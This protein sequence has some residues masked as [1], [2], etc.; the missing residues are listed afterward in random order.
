[1]LK[2]LTQL[3]FL[4]KMVEVEA[5]LAKKSPKIIL[6]HGA[7]ASPMSFNYIKA[8]LPT[9]EY[10]V[11]D[12]STVDGFYPN[13]EKMVD[14]LKGDNK[15]YVLSHSMGGIYAM[16]LTQY[17]NI[18]RSISVSTP[19]EGLGIA[20]WAKYMMPNYQ[21]FKDVSLRAMPI[22]QLKDIKIKMP[23]TQVV[24]TRGS[25]PWVKDPNDGVVTIASMSTRKDI[26]YVY[27]KES[28][29]EIMMSDELV[30]IVKKQ[31]FG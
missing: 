22:T 4:R 25:V 31:F 27:I 5:A 3:F 21:L 23:W 11:V 30:E 17:I 14:Q 29:N 1:M 16:H 24:T 18:Q 26:D 6:I 20:D 9:A 12:Y 19:F 13:L 28:H 2:A 15:Y 8:R 10:H 7:N